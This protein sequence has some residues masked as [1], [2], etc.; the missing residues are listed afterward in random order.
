MQSNVWFICSYVDGQVW[1][2]IC[3]YVGGRL[4]NCGVLWYS[5]F[6]FESINK[7]TTIK[8]YEKLSKIITPDVLLLLWHHCNAATTHHWW[9]WKL[10]HGIGMT[11]RSTAKWVTGFRYCRCNW[12]SN[13]KSFQATLFFFKACHS[14]CNTKDTY[15]G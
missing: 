11:Q 3:S 15:T 14:K 4:F 10:H 12:I 8:E 1:F 13:E 7:C 9:V 6:P 2:F 5:S